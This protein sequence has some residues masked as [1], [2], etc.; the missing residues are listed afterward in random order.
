MLLVLYN[1]SFF[2]FQIQEKDDLPQKLCKECEE[3]LRIMYSFRKQA[4]ESDY[5]LKKLILSCTAIKDEDSDNDFKNDNYNEFVNYYDE[6]VLLNTDLSQENN[7]RGRHEKQ[8]NSDSEKY[9]NKNNPAGAETT[10]LRKLS[11]RLF[12]NK[13]HEIDT[14]ATNNLDN[15]LEQLD[16]TVK[17]ESISNTYDCIFCK[18][19]FETHEYL[20]VHLMEHNKD[21]PFKCDECNEEYLLETS[22]VAHKKKYHPSIEYSKGQYK[23]VY[24]VLSFFSE[25]EL[26][27]HI[28]K[29]KSDATK[30]VKEEP[31]R[32]KCKLCN[33][34]YEKKR[35]LL[36]HFKVH[37]REI[38]AKLFICDFCQKEFT[39]KGALKRHIEL[40]T[41]DKRYKCTEC[42]KTYSRYDQF[43]S[44]LRK[45][46]G[47]K[48]YAC[49]HC[50]KGM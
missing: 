10:C 50:D 1:F 27:S 11:N 30:N 26:L 6:V 7:H 44:H 17:A 16:S 9:L 20:L 14:L 47:I 3:K 19:A 31:K 43:T 21:K 48:P 18:M 24:C 40:H 5:E 34:R 35:S 37:T 49:E 36:S 4:L 33:Q 13:Q 38:K 8:L 2:F 39:Q 42:P 25:E 28:C 12:L 45:H 23:C 15:G 32:F 41:K 29:S 46:S 22:L